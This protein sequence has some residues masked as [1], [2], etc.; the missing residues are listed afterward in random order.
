MISQLKEKSDIKIFILYLMKQI[1]RPIDFVTLNDIVV[2]DEFVNQFDFMDCFYELYQSG[3]IEKTFSDGEE[4][5]SITSQGAV[6]AETLESNIIPIIRERSTRSAL[7]L[8][9]FKR[10]G[11][12]TGCSVTELPDG[13]CAMSCSASD[14]DGEFLKLTLTLDTRRQAELM[15]KNYDENPELVYR[16]ILGVLSG[17]INYLADAW[18]NDEADD[19]CDGE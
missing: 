8:L 7:R 1:E 10:R 17:D 5:Y 2:Q 16:T 18:I 15:K 3:A 12:K 11:A 14:I 4:L 13:K 9:S 6:A 19:A